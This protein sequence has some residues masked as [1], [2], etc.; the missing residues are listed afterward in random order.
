M[1]DIS[2]GMKAFIS[3]LKLF[4]QDMDSY[5]PPNTGLGIERTRF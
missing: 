3:L 2:L 1:G 4:I 5:L